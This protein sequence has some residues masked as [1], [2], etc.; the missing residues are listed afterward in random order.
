MTKE[1]ELLRFAAEMALEYA[2]SIDS[3]AATLS[4]TAIEAMAAFD[5]ALPDEPNE[6]S[7]T[8]ALRNRFGNPATMGTTAQNYFGFVA[9][10][11]LP[12]TLGASFIVDAWD[13]NAGLP[14]SSPIA[15]KI[16]DVDSAWLVDLE[17]PVIVWPRPGEVNTGAFDPFDEIADWLSN[18]AGWMH[19]DCAFGLW[20]LADPTRADPHTAVLAASSSDRGLVRTS[21]SGTVRGRGRHH[22]RMCCNRRRWRM[23]ERTTQ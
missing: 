1:S 22:D 13:Q 2:A 4:E 16:L 18:R 12:V 6:P 3:R 10:A 19:V 23:R 11:T 15:A 17:G 5:E 8:L 20:A 9:G 7:E 14:A 21:Y